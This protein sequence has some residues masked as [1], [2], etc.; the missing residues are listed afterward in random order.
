MENWKESPKLTE[1]FVKGFDLLAQKQIGRSINVEEGGTP[2]YIKSYNPKRGVFNGDIDARN[3]PVTVVYS[4]C[5]ALE[6]LK[7][8]F[9]KKTLP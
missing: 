9:E 4:L 6:S 7:K 8:N 5:Y 2:V 3:A 1:S